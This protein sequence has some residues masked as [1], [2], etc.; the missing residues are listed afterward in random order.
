MKKYIDIINENNESTAAQI[1]KFCRERLGWELY[2]NNPV[3]IFEGEATIMVEG[4]EIAL[5]DVNR[6]NR[7]GKV[8]SLSTAQGNY[9]L[10]ITIMIDNSI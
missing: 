2:G 3:N 9:T 5:E 8:S 6:L 4:S 10:Q 1:I 7:F